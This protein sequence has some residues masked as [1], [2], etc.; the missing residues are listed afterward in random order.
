M[1]NRL[2][3]EGIVD[4][5]KIDRLSPEAEVFYYRLLV[6]ADDL[7]LMDA[8]PVILRARCFPLKETLTPAR[9]QVWVDALWE[10]GLV[11]K[12]EIEGK[13]Y[14]KILS[15]SQR[16]RSHGKYPL[17]VDGQLSVNCHT[18]VA[19]GWVGLGKGKGKGASNADEVLFDATSAAWTI[20]DQFREKWIEAFPAI[21]VEVE[22]SKA[23]AW[24]ISNPKNQK[25][26]Y[27]RF[28]TNWLTKAQD[29]AP[30]RG[31]FG[32]QPDLGSYV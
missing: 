6:V 16:V 24:L 32:S 14:V 2:L 21:D 27:A 13:P 12:Y 19:L 8:R 18:D 4:S 11:G 31:G 1:P 15:W 30:G 10:S 9:I 25:S 17:P 3:K 29:R 26:N 23:G 22:F 7:G 28:L 20:P 5:E